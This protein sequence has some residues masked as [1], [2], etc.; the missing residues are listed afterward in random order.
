M[1][2][3]P[4]SVLPPE[5]TVES[6]AQPGSC[7]VKATVPEPALGQGEEPL[8]TQ[9]APSLPQL[10]PE[11]PPKVPGAQESSRDPCANRLRLPSL[12][13]HSSHLSP[14]QRAAARHMR[15]LL[16]EAE[17]IPT[18]ASQ[19]GGRFN[20]GMGT[21]FQGPSANDVSPLPSCVISEHE[22]QR[23]N[24]RVPEASHPSTS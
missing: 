4:I 13:A 8:S 10:F 16:N 15:F 6:W 12:R 7:T 21:P 20:K 3:L 1:P 9:P 14:P 5:S 23:C 19:S 24:Q 11:T 2:H 22:S 17:L 18:T